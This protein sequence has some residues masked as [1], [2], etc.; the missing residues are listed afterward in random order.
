VKNI[1]KPDTNQF[2]CV[3]ILDLLSNEQW[4]TLETLPFDPQFAQSLVQ[5]QSMIYRFF[6][7][8]LSIFVPYSLLSAKHKQT[9]S[10]HIQ[11]IIITHYYFHSRGISSTV[12]RCIEKETGKEF[13]AKIIDLGASDTADS[14]HMLEATRA[15][16]QVLRQVM[17]HRYISNEKEI[18]VQR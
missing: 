11:L 6:H 17:G 7:D 15:E 2:Y 12:R 8:F 10:S 3:A 5:V 18:A 13:A 9:W 16:I 14:K 4:I 1:P